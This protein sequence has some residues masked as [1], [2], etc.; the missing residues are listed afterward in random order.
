[1]KYLV[2]GAAGFIGS[3]VVERLT[4]AGHE[5]VGIDN[6]NDY[7]QVSL[8]EDRLKRIV[9]DKFV[10]KNL[11]LADREGIATLFAEEQ[12]DK[13]IHLAAQAGVRYS[14]D[15][16]LAY[17]D[18][19][20]VGHLTIL[21]GCRH[22]KI[23]HLVYASSSSVYG[24]NKKMPFDTAD[25]VD[26]P[27][28]LYAATKKSNELMAHTYSHLY[29]VPTTGLRFFTVYGPWG[30]PDMALFKFTKAILNGDE[31]DVYNN[32][33]MQRD[34]TY[35]DDIVEGIIR[36]QEVIPETNNDWSVEAGS[37][38]TSSAPYRV[39]NIGH[40]SPVKLMEYIEALEDALG[41]EAKKNFMPMQPG[42]VYATYAD[43][44]D[45]F[46]ATGYIPQVKVKEGVKAFADWYKAYYKL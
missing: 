21:E 7:Y 33:D 25:S 17:A 43:T 3:A 20:L 40:G 13:V 10:F 32:G 44:E 11:D 8:K 2:T 45:L 24:L 36:I 42:D 28:S 22:H 16:P 26:H 19:N 14:I 34:F 30:R 1:M 4:D 18:S 23:K 39:F 38:A 6:M 31:I 41:V 37:P 12:F 5:V 27:I 9:H 15:N 46:K 29:G 35:I